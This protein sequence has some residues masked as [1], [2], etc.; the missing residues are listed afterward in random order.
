MRLPIA[1][2]SLLIQ[3]GAV[4]AV[5]LA[6]VLHPHQPGNFLLPALAQGSLAAVFSRV[7]R[8][9]A[10]W[11]LL[12][13]GFLPL[14][15]IAH[16]AGVPPWVYL[17]A[18]V[19]LLLVYWT[20]FRTRV[21]LYLSNR[22]AWQVLEAQLPVDRPFRFVDLGSG[23]GGVPLYLASRS[24]N[25]EWIGIEIAPLPWLISRVRAWLHGGG[26]SFLRRDYETLDLGSFDVVFAFLSPAAMPRLWR[27]AR[28]Q[29]RPG[30]LLLS[31]SF[32]VPGQPPDGAWPADDARRHVLY[33]WRM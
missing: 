8:Q 20:S 1:F 21:P 10:W 7:W 14:A 16:G 27:Q 29:M 32:S 17:A 26:V 12:H 15:W 33:A 24:A 18:F 6:V 30:S 11:Q 22:Q 13:F 2:Q 25:G 5:A 19:L 9:P 3:I 4:L 28:A 31:L 23:L